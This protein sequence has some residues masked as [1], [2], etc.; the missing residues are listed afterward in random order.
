[1]PNTASVNLSYDDAA[2]AV[3]GEVVGSSDT[4]QIYLDYDRSTRTDDDGF[5]TSSEVDT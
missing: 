5:C 4:S 1:M 3:K 2:D